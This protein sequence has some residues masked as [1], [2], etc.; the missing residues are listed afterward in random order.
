MKAAGVWTDG[1]RILRREAASAEQDQAR[2]GNE[3]HFGFH[4][5]LRDDSFHWMAHGYPLK[6][7]KGSILRT[8]RTPT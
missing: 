7:S 3:R 5:E 4:F 2:Q 8:L 1:C 6:M